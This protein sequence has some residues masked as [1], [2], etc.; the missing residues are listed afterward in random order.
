MRAKSSI[1]VAFFIPQIG[2]GGAERVVANLV[3]QFAQDNVNVILITKDKRPNEYKIEEGVSRFCLTKKEEKGNRLQRT[4]KHLINLRRI[5]KDNAIDVLVSFNVPANYL[6]IWALLGSKTKHIISVRNA[7]DFLFKTTLEKILAKF[8]FSLADGAVFQT[9]DA[10]EW[11]P[12]K[13]R[14]KAV[15]IYNPVHSQFYNIKHEPLP[16]RVVTCGRLTK[17]KNHKMLINAF[18]YVV[19]QF[20]KAELH[21]YGEG[22]L[23]KELANLIEKTGL[24]NNVFLEGRVENVSSVLS[25]AT[26]FVLSSD[27]EGAP[28]ALMEA[29][30]VGVPSV[31]TDCPCGGPRMLLHE[32]KAGL[33]VQ[34]DNKELMSKAILQ[35]LS[36][37][38]LLCDMGK[39]A[40]KEACKFKE[41][42]IYKLWLN[43]TNTVI[44]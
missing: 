34:V 7:P 35:L 43:Y 44:S 36:S 18:K 16:F 14:R 12:Y 11:F 23:G 40:K 24:K 30:A 41:E 26:L 5:C 3:N 37:R 32:S 4:F 38:E 22:N 17:Q 9:K 42:E 6:A 28:N 13:L 25:A 10:Q 21:I 20:P 31:S 29:M 8:L 15:I 2:G 19:E 33:L 39:N 1:K 27:V